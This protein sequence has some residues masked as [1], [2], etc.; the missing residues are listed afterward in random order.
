MSGDLR[1]ELSILP[2][3]TVLLLHLVADHRAAQCASRA[4]DCGACSPTDERSDSSA[5]ASTNERSLFA[6][7]QGCEQPI[8]VTSNAPPR[9]PIIPC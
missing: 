4:T 1:G 8:E 2:V 5:S 9:T 6:F 7:V 3:L